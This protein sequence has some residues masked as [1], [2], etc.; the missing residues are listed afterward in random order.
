MPTVSTAPVRKTQDWV[1][2]TVRDSQQAAVDTVSLWAKV[3]EKATP[4][5]KVLSL[6]K[7]LPSPKSIVDPTFDLAEKVLGAQRQFASSV[8]GPVEPAKATRKASTGA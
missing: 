6:T 4:A 7:Q 8:I 3:V 5:T 1:L 2:R